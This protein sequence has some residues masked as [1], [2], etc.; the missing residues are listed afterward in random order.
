MKG[1][2]SVFPPQPEVL[3]SE[4]KILT[5]STFKLME[6]EKTL[7][8]PV[9]RKGGDVLKVDW[10]PA[11]KAFFGPAEPP[12]QFFHPLQNR[13]KEDSEIV[14]VILI[15]L[16]FNLVHSSFDDLVGVMRSAGTNYFSLLHFLYF[17]SF[18]PSHS[19]FLTFS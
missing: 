1:Y 9:V 7:L 2:R 19:V 15:D 8:F 10:F 13:K 17:L 18:S 6:L 11:T 16:G 12:L 14:D 5:C 3:K 4:P